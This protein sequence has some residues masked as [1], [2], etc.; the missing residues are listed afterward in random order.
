MERNTKNSPPEDFSPTANHHTTYGSR[1][2]SV[3]AGVGISISDVPDLPLPRRKHL[4]RPFDWDDCVVN[5]APACSA[6]QKHAAQNFRE[7]IREL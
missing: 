6:R 5:S 2:R 7:V 1:F 4:L 3:D